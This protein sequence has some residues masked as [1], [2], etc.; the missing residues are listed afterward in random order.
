MNEKAVY[1]L[2]LDTSLDFSGKL[3]SLLADYQTAGGDIEELRNMIAPVMAEIL[4]QIINPVSK[5][6]P[7]LNTILMD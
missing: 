7:D 1:K 4:F 5:K 6:Y 3:N 2:A